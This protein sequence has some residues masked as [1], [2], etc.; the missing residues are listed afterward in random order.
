[1]RPENEVRKEIEEL[2][3]KL[4]LKV[5]ENQNRI[6]SLELIE[7]SQRMDKLL[8]ELNDAVCVIEK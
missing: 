6:P 7:V 2:R 8:N 5:K 3:T 4:N 1:M